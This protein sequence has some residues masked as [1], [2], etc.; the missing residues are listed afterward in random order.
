MARIERWKRFRSLP[1]DIRERVSKLESFFKEEGVE[2][3]Y[4][5]GSFPRSVNPD[6]ID[7]AVLYHGDFAS[8]RERLWEELGTQRLDLVNLGQAPPLLRFE[9]IRSGSVIYKRDDNSENS[10][11]MKTLREYKDTSHLRKRQEIILREKTRKWCCN[12]K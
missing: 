3:A 10:F 9:V 6:D 4:L 1:E 5:F 2:L 7:I 8:L 11:E 12:Q